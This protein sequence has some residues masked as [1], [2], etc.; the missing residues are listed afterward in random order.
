MTA[1]SPLAVVAAAGLVIASLTLATPGRPASAA[2]PR[3]TAAAQSRPPLAAAVPHSDSGPPPR[4]PSQ[5]A[6]GLAVGGVV[7]AWRWPLAPAPGIGRRFSVGPTPWSRGHRGVDLIPAHGVTDVLAPAPGVVSFTGVVAGTPV[8]VVDHGAGLRTTYQ[9]VQAEVARG[10]QVSAGTVIG[11]LLGPG[12]HCAPAT[13]LHW[14]AVRGT[15][16]VD[17]LSLLGLTSRAVLLPL[18]R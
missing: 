17:P 7:V 3:S 2:A 8:V 15:R 14:G 6:Q 4:S 11:R 12:S 16:Y 1:L 18:F 5:A 10:Q 9:P 13:C